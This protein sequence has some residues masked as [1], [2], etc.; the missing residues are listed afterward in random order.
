MSLLGDLEMSIT[1][2]PYNNKEHFGRAFHV[3]NTMRQESML[4]DVTVSAGNRKIRAHRAVLASASPYFYAMFTGDLSESRQEIIVLKEI[5]PKALELLIEYC[6]KA[7][8][9]VNEE[10]VQVTNMLLIHIF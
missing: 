6:Y 7:E 5:D 2:P 3:L 4:T 8:V 10:N 9:Q 1:V